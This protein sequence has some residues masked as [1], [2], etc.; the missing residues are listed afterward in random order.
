MNESTAT[1]NFLFYRIY[2]CFV[3]VFPA[4]V[5]YFVIDDNFNFICPKL[6]VNISLNQILYIIQICVMDYYYGCCKRYYNKFNK[7]FFEKDNILEAVLKDICCS[8]FGVSGFVIIVTLV[9]HF[10]VLSLRF[11]MVFVN[12][13]RYLMLSILRY[14]LT[15]T[16][17][18]QWCNLMLS[19]DVQILK[20]K[21]LMKSVVAAKYL[22]NHAE[23]CTDLTDAGSDKVDLE[24]IEGV[25]KLYR[26]TAEKHEALNEYYG[27][28]LAFHISLL[29]YWI[30]INSYKVW[31]CFAN[32]HDCVDYPHVFLSLIII[33]DFTN[34]VMVSAISISLSKKVTTIYESYRKY[35]ITCTFLHFLHS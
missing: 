33:C 25:V 17:T 31:Y 26:I 9:A 34:V 28:F 20:I 11:A 22:Y 27:T 32:A 4:I 7:S 14:V 15:L 16:L 30:L 13:R 12:F 1:G 10:A 8:N 3:Y 35:H 21:K 18:L 29:V 23:E 2:S 6:S 24:T 5:F 19:V